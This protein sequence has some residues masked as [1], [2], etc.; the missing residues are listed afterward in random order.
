MDKNLKKR[1]TMHRLC[2]KGLEVFHE[3]GYYNTS[4]GRYPKGPC[5]YPKVHFTIILNPKKI[6]LLPLYKI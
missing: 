6:T 4:S 1:E 5:P 3:K 2:A